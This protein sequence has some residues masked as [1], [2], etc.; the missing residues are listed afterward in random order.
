MVLGFFILKLCEMRRPFL[1][2]QRS[3]FKSEVETMPFY[4]GI[5][6]FPVEISVDSECPVPEEQTPARHKIITTQ[7]IIQTQDFHP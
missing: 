7:E 1:E 5:I 3:L 2:V 6:K 4:L